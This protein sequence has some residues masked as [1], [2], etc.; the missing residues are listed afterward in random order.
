MCCGGAHPLRQS[1]TTS[2]EALG[3]CMCAAT[4]HAL[5]TGGCRYGTLGIEKYAMNGDTISS[6]QELVQGLMAN[7]IVVAFWLHGL[8]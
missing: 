8:R 1:T 4:R 5:S 2:D 7:I 6:K 3:Q